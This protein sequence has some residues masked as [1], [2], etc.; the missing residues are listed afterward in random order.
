M[1]R[2]IVI[3]GARTNN[4]QDLDLDLPLGRFTVVTGVSGSGKSSLVFDTVYAEGQRRY[5]Q[6]LSTYARLF[7]DRMQRPDVDTISDIPPALALRQKNA[8]SNARSTVG[9]ITEINDYLRLLF[10]AIGRTICPQCGGEVARDTVADACA[11][12]VA[13]PAPYVFTAPFKIGSRPLAHALSYLAA[14]GYHRLFL[15]GS[16]VDAQSAGEASAADGTLAVV[17]DRVVVEGEATAQRVREAMEKAFYLGADQARAIRMERVDGRLQPI[18]TMF[19]DRRFNCSHCGTTFPEPTPALLSANSP[20]GACPEC[21]GFGRTV[22]LDLR[23]VI[24]NGNLSLRQGLVAP[25]RT[26]AYKEMQAWMLECARRRRI[27]LTA[28]Y[29]EFTADERTWLLDGEGGERHAGEERWPG[30][31]GFFKWMERRRYKTHVRILLARYRKFVSCAACAGARLRPQALN[32]R[33]QGRNIGDLG[34]MPISTLAQWIDQLPVGRDEGERSAAVMRELRNRLGYLT[35]VG[36]GYL[37]LDRAARTLSGGEAQRI[38]LASALGSRLTRT[39]YALDEPTVGLHARDSRRLLGVLRNLRDIG[40]TV[41]VVEHDP[42]MVREADYLVELGPGGGRDG[43]NLVFGGPPADR[44]K[45]A[46]D[47]PSGRVLMMRAIARERRLGKSDPALRI[48]G[49]AE[50]NLK[51]ITVSIPL[52]RMVCITGVSGSGKSTLV[53]EVLYN[54]YLARTG[55]PV[56]EIG[57]CKRIEGLERLDRI[58]HM[59]QEGLARSTR[60]NPATYIKLYDSIR[61]LF[62][63]TQDARRAGIEA[64]HFSFN[65]AGGRCERCHGMG[66][67]TIEMHFMADL[68]VECDACD[69]RRF[70]SHVLGVKYRGLNINEVLALTVE[71]ARG[72]F[73]RQNQIVERLNTLCAVGLG[74][75]QLGQPTSTLSGGEAQRLR[76]SAFLLEGT[77]SAG[78]SRASAAGRRMFILDEPTTGL[79]GSD[80]RNLLRVFNRL[81]G[82][83]HTLLVIEHNLELIAN[84]DFV[85]DLGPEGGADGGRVVI[86][87]TP[88]E[89]AACEASHTG[90]ELRRLF[91][92]PVNARSDKVRTALRKAAGF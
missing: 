68:E 63:A 1:E 57:A 70:Q 91:G 10:C 58:V 21:Q 59:G 61:K 48:I 84:A 36:L 55:A 31:R 44:S 16:V 22:E 81:I 30:I 32:V 72:F 50:H 86:S 85:I 15:D 83:G 45:R 90:R 38:H 52:G 71:E 53:E 76:L 20:M 66:V 18:A 39:L 5:V 82:E 56:S 3:R 62:A 11:R 2:S 78:S 34:R 47:E 88:L 13:A 75:L 23:K 33:I 74:Y 27:R 17:I 51:D 35:A 4:L 24:P 8:I 37:T 28:P 9:S 49:A 80:I 41:I 60:S 92:L 87:G 73:A 26:P 77:D 46:G 6:S 79:A 64:K 89:V 42:L 54:N 29:R 69:G 43:G 14:N 40:N 19:F 25:W 12:I 67:V 65:V 7:L